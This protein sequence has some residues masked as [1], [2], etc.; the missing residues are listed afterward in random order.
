[1]M[2]LLLALSLLASTVLERVTNVSVSDRTTSAA[3]INWKKQTAATQYQVRLR[4]VQGDV[5][6]KRKT[7]SRHLTLTGLEADTSYQVQVR[8]L[9]NAKSGAWSKTVPFS[10]KADTNPSYDDYKAVAGSSSG[11]WQN[12]T[13][14]T[15]GDTTT[16]VEIDPDG[17]AAFTLD[18]GG[19]VFGLLDPDPKTYESTYD[20]TGTVFTAEDDD[21]FGDLTI[22]I[23]PNGN[24]TAQITLEGLN[25]PVVGIS[26]ITADGTLYDDSVDMDYQITFIDTLTAEGVMNLT[27][28]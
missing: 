17:R 5:I 22:T 7:D 6:R 16:T 20:E 13:Y 25:V 8:A 12:L 10:T 26:Q 14:A 28:L 2:P 24:D 1:M 23:V 3:T 19:L 27:K 15:S 18:L 9:S 4:D 11:S 21:L